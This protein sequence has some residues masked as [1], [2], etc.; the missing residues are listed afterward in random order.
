[1]I[2]SSLY[3]TIY[4]FQSEIDIALKPQTDK[5]YKTNYDKLFI[6]LYTLEFRINVGTLIIVGM[7]F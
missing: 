7:V 6:Y 4:S 1:M 2:I 5:L 3:L